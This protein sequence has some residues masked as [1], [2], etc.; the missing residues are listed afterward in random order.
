MSIRL[1]RLGTYA[2]AA[3]ISAALAGYAAYWQGFYTGA[4]TAL[5]TVSVFA[6]DDPAETRSCVTARQ[7]VYVIR[8]AD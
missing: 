8:S 5:C 7:P 2:F 6:G 3:M 4:D 1:K